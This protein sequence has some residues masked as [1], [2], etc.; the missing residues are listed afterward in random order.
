MA[1]V[2]PLFLLHA[3]IDF[4]FPLHNYIFLARPSDVYSLRHIA[5]GSP[6]LPFFQV[7]FSG[8]EVDISFFSFPPIL[9][10][11][12]SPD[13]LKTH[14]WLSAK[15]FFPFDQD[16]KDVS[17]QHHAV[18]SV[19]RPKVYGLFLSSFLDLHYG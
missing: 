18:P 14:T 12:L 5:V 19:F 4:F 8:M 17:Q 11:S 3:R 7:F 6:F 16:N 15:T 1:F 9:G 10:S 2:Q 13:P